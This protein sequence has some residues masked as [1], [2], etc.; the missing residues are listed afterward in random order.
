[1]DWGRSASDLFGRITSLRLRLAGFMTGLIKMPSDEGT[2]RQFRYLNY[3]TEETAQRIT[4]AELHCVFNLD[5]TIIK[6]NW[7]WAIL[8]LGMIKKPKRAF[9]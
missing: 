3:L 4:D 9:F 2:G 6:E 1:M 7:Q 5:T 8:D